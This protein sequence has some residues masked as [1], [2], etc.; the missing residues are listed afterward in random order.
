MALDDIDEGDL[1][2]RVR[3]STFVSYILQLDI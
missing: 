1:L 3:P 2:K